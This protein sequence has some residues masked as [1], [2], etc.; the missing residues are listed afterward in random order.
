M[1]V[2]VGGLRGG[3]GEAERDRERGKANESEAQ[4]ARES[5]RERERE[6]AAREKEG[7]T[8]MPGRYISNFFSQPGCFRVR[9]KVRKYQM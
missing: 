7:G 8:E 2:D 3:E 4:R 5:E 6:R 9:R 1:P